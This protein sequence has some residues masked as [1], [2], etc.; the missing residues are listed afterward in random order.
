MIRFKYAAGLFASLSLTFVVVAPT[1]ACSSANDYSI[2]KCTQTCAGS[3]PVTL[4]DVCEPGDKSGDDVAK[5]AE[6]ALADAGIQCS[7]SCQKTDS[8]CKQK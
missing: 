3:S 5:T 4:P 8:P 7:L 6:K 1:A 2:F